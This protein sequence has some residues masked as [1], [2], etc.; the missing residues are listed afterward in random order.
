MIQKKERMFAGGWK[1]TYFVAEELSIEELELA[2]YFW[3][4][5]WNSFMKILPNITP[6]EL[7]V[8]SDFP[9]NREYTEDKEPLVRYYS[10]GLD[11]FTDLIFKK[12]NISEIERQESLLK[13]SMH[14]NA[15]IPKYKL[16]STVYIINS[17]SLCIFGTDFGEYPSKDDLLYLTYYN[18]ERKFKTVECK[19]IDHITSPRSLTSWNSQLILNPV[20]ELTDTVYSSDDII[21]YKF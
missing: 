19:V 5:G 6:D 4:K 7:L 15:Y 14:N 2:Q 3:H 8:D 1:E 11:E 9:Y 16:H 21:I 20:P 10:R 17:E 13:F 18:K 12:K